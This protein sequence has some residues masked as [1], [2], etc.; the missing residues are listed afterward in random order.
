[1]NEMIEILNGLGLELKETTKGE[2]HGP[3]NLSMIFGH[4]FSK[5]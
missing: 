4:S 5:N 3:R 2:Y 1:M